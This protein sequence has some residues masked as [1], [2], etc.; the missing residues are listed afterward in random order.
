[1]S[2]RNEQFVPPLNVVEAV[3]ECAVT[4]AIEAAR[5]QLDLPAFAA[6]TSVWL[7][8]APQLQLP[9][10]TLNDRSRCLVNDAE[11][12]L[13]FRHTFKGTRDLFFAQLK[14]NEPEKETGFS[15]LL[16][17]GEIK[18]SGVHST[19][20]MTSSSVVYNRCGWIDPAKL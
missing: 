19:V 18:K 10:D 8:N 7:F 4:P 1:M 14:M 12:R 15:S 5:T 3:L 16:I 20:T 17:R 11:I 13:R 6:Q 2:W 9:A